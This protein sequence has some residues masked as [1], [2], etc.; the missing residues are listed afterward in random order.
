MKKKWYIGL[1]TGT[2]LDG[3]IDIALLR[4]DGEYI[5][6]FGPY[7]LIP[8][9]HSTRVL[10][11]KT[12][13]AA[14]LWKFDK[15]E[16]D[17]FAQTEVAIT[18]SQTKAIQEFIKTSKIDINDIAGVGFHGQTVLHRA[19]SKSLIGATR[20]LGDGQ[21][22]ADQLGIPVVYDFRTNDI[23]TGGQGA[24]LCPIYH[25][26][27]LKKIDAGPD[28]AFLN[29][30]G[31][32]N[33]TWQSKDHEIFAFDTGPANAPINDWIKHFNK[34][35]MDKDGE[36]A[37]S[38]SVNENE[39]KKM[40]QDPYFKKSPPK[41]LDRFDFSY[42]MVDGM[43][44]EDGA[45]TLT[46]FSAASVEKAINLLPQRPNKLIISGGGRKNPTLMNEISARSEVSIETAESYG[47]RGDAIEAEC[48]AFL[49]A[50]KIAN[51]PISFPKT[52]GVKQPITGGKIAKAK[53][54]QP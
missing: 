13:D 22:M 24:P 25:A 3:N 31:V 20:Q 23:K 46:A 15:K 14:Q 4:T 12:L 40:L 16:P 2:V 18:G 47:W 33:L 9:S 7:A 6:E 28:T 21:A 37:A 48:F 29:L 42:T 41:S 34:G 27:L 36:I 1:M 52:T 11:E 43:S 8:Y 5:E 49:A 44:L 26:A 17:I 38:G 45:A 50:R 51:L 10:L 53:T 32:G 30:G 54:A 19:P 39:L 35:E